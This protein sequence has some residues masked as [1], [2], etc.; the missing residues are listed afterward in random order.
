MRIATHTL[1]LAATLSA[2]PLAGVSAQ[3]GGAASIPSSLRPAVEA[4][5]ANNSWLLEQ[6][7]SICEI[8]APP[9]NE[10][11]RAAELQRRFEALGLANVRTDGEGNVIG[12]RRGDG[13]GP[14]VVLSGHLDT[15]FPEGT[16]VKVKREGT[17]FS[18][19]GI[20]DDCRGLAVVLGVARAMADTRVR[21]PGTIIFVGTVGEEGAGNLRGVR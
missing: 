9:F 10:A 13:S 6:Q 14:T 5:K 12:E 2:L 21:T 19:P 11:G 15:V 1:T 3:K 8:P 16:D 18:A 17:R 4:V 20:A 7:Q